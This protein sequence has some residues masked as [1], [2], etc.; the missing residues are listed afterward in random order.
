MRMKPGHW[1]FELVIG[2][3]RSGPI[4]VDVAPGAATIHLRL[5]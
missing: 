5:R 2:D 1:R 3:V 4:E